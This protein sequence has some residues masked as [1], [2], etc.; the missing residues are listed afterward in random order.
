LVEELFV[1]TAAGVVVT[2]RLSPLS[3]ADEILV[4][5]DGATRLAVTTTN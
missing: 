5:A 4:V 1:A 2:H 3:A